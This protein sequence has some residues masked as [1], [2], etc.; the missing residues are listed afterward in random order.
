MSIDK[1]TAIATMMSMTGSDDFDMITRLLEQNAWCVDLAVEEYNVFQTNQLSAAQRRDRNDNNVHN[2]GG[3]G[4]GR[5][6]G[7]NVGNEGGN[8]GGGN[9]V[10]VVGDF[11][12]QMRAERN[13]TNQTFESRQLQEL[14]KAPDYAERLGADGWRGCGDKAARESKYI[15]LNIQE[16]GNFW[17][18]QLDRDV[19]TNDLVKDVVKCD[20]LLAQVWKGGDNYRDIVNAYPGVEHEELPV[21]LFLDYRSRMKLK[22]IN[23]KQ[24]M[25]L[26]GISLTGG[27]QQRLQDNAR[28]LAMAAVELLTSFVDRQRIAMERE[29]SMDRTNTDGAQNTMSQSNTTE[30]G[31]APNNNNNNNTGKSNNNNTGGD[32]VEAA[33]KIST[34]INNNPA[35]QQ[36]SSSG[37]EPS[38]SEDTLAKYRAAGAGD[39]ILK[40]RIKLPVTAAGG[41]ASSLEDWDV[42]LPKSTPQRAFTRGVRF[43]LKA[44]RNSAVAPRTIL[45]VT[46]LD[47]S[48][49]Q[50]EIFAEIPADALSDANDGPTLGDV[51]GMRSGEVLWIE[52]ASA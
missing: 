49:K 16:P 6:T 27:S 52:L 3:G 41:G 18:H 19:W 25:N 38:D 2:N 45:R 11:R 24:L 42:F 28:A 23:F 43:E 20:Y 30:D 13:P 5:G 51:E 31:A 21:I 33:L 35:Q 48:R 39:G 10:R 40:L 15:I 14:F 8:A 37:P 50:Q 1:D 26:A 17:S 44:N 22:S 9:D 29:G 7:G 34:Q 12:N 36:Q 32:D 46:R 4:S 47:R